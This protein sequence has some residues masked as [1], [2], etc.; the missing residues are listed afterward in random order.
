MEVLI[1]F[2]VII[3]ITIVYHAIKSLVEI[4]GQK[5]RDK[6][7]KKVFSKISINFEEEEKDID[8]KMSQVECTDWKDNDWVK[9]K[10]IYNHSLIRCPSCKKGF[11]V[12]RDGKYGFFMGCS[13][14][15]GC[16]YTEKIKEQEEQEDII[17]KIRDAYK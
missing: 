4:I 6:A 15:P 12:V 13:R 5:V 11:L 9:E 14:Y 2:A 17:P 8:I 7:A 1:F 10:S 3:G 16:T